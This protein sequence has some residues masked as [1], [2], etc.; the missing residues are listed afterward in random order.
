MLLAVHISDGILQLPW[1]VGGLLLSAILYW[2]GVRRIRDEEIP[3][4]ALLTAVFFIASTMHVPVGRTS[5]HLL[6]NALVGVLLGWRAAVAIPVGLLLQA[7]LLGH[8]GF[9]CLG[10]N[11]CVQ[12]APA[13]GAWLLFRGLH[14]VPCIARPWCRGVLVAFSSF[15]AILSVVYGVVLLKSNVLHS[16]KDFD[17]SEANHVTGHPLTIGISLG[18]SLIA[19]WL[20]RHMENAPEFPLGFLVGELTVLATSLLN[21]GVLVL[22]GDDT[23]LIGPP[24][25]LLVIHLPIA[26]IEGLILGVAVGFLFRVKPDMLGLPKVQSTNGNQEECGGPKPVLCAADQ[27][28]SVPVK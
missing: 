21:C 25:M 27:E 18:L 6:G 19:A 8:G 7:M 4:I 1:V 28:W 11:A 12:V 22:G 20:E 9:F 13:L 24:L 3:R 5:V 15:L 14:R 17:P 26:V 16:L 2:M 23:Y 10:V